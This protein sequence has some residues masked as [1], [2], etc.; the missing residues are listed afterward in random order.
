MTLFSFKTEPWV[1]EFPLLP[2]PHM[3]SQRKKMDAVMAIFFPQSCDNKHSKLQCLIATNISFS[4]P[5]FC[6]QTR[7]ALPQVENWV[8][9]PPGHRSIHICSISLH[10]PVATTSM[11]F[12]W[13][14]SR[15]E[16]SKP[17]L[18]LHLLTILRSKPITCST[19]IQQGSQI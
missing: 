9:L 16:K 4:C 3:G 2:R 13:K 11:F 1:L 10:E 15:A 7:M 19:Q 5:W 6:E 12:S 18:A 8:G 14:L 17:M